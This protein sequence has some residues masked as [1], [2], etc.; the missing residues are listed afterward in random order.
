MIFAMPRVRKS[1]M[2][3]RPS[4]HPTASNVPRLLNAH[5]TAILVAQSREPSKSFMKGVKDG[6]YRDAHKSLSQQIQA[7]K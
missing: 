1:Q 6:L 4:L 2:T 3:M 7:S 5:V